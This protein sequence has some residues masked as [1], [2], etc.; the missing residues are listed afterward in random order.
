MHVYNSNYAGVYK[1]K[2][3]ERT[4]VTPQDAKIEVRTTHCKE[5]TNTAKINAVPT[6]KRWS[7]GWMVGQVWAA[8]LNFK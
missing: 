5:V 7:R 2:R 3:R 4:Y 8:N 1:M 6:L